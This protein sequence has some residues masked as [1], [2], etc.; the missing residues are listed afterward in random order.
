MFPYVRY[1][2]HPGS[3]ACR[4]IVL[5]IPHLVHQHGKGMLKV[6]AVAVFVPEDPVSVGDGLFCIVARDAECVRNRKSPCDRSHYSGGKD[7][8]GAMVAGRDMICIILK[9]LAGFA[10]QAHDSDFSGSEGNA[11]CNATRLG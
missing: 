1:L 9:G 10:V 8:A 5:Q 11:S 3:G 4:R 2:P 7:I 6:Y